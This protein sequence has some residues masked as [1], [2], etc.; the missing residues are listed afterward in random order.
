MS[1][2]VGQMHSAELSTTLQP[3]LYGAL[4]PTILHGFLVGVGVGVGEGVCVVTVGTKE[5]FKKHFHRGK[6]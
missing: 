5:N 2:H 6:D 4:Q 1:G 3:T